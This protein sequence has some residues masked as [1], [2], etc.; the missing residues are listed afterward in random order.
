MSIDNSRLK[1]LDD[2]HKLRVASGILAARAWS[3]SHREGRFAPE[4][5]LE[6]SELQEAAARV[7]EAAEDME[8]AAASPAPGRRCADGEHSID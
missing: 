1:M 4:V 8:A 2:A 5:I 3:L 7:C 6:V